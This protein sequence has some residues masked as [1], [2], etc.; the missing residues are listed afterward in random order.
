MTREIKIS[1]HGL[2]HTGKSALIALLLLALKDAGVDKFDVLFDEHRCQD[3]SVATIVRKI[4]SNKLDSK[5]LAKFFNDKDLLLNI[6]ETIDNIGWYY[7]NPDIK[8]QKISFDFP[9]PLELEK[10]FIPRPNLPFIHEGEFVD[11]IW[12][13]GTIGY[14]QASASLNWLNVV[15]YRDV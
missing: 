11:V 15:A 4:L 3:N 13:D 6:R 12:N 8:P 10:P 5:E 2:P 14:K 9:P 1:V 7:E